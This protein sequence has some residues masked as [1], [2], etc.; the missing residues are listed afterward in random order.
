MTTR[1]DPNRPAGP[2]RAVRALAA[3]LVLAGPAPLRADEGPSPAKIEMGAIDIRSLLD[4]SVEAVMR[5]P[6]RAS[7]A[8]AS[9]FVVTGQD[10]RRHGSRTLAEALGFVPGL[11]AYPGPFEQVGVRGMGILGDFTTR[12]LVLVDGHPLANAMGGDL[13]RGFPVPLSAVEKIE[14]IKGPVGSVYGPTAFLGVVNV[15][16]KGAAPGGEAWAGLEAAQGEVRAGEAS[17]A[18]RGRPGEAEGLVAVDGWKTKGQDWTYADVPPAAFTVRGEDD[19]DALSAYA[20]GQ[21][22]DLGVAGACGHAWRRMPAS[23]PSGGTPLG[24]NTLGGLTCFGEATWQA[25]LSDALTLRGRGAFDYFQRRA[26]LAYAPPPDGIGT[27][28]HGGHDQWETAELRVEW[29]LSEALQLDAGATGQLHQIVQHSRSDAVPLLAVDLSPQFGTLNTWLQAELHPLATVTLHAGVTYFAHSLFAD[30]LTPKL[31]AVWQPTSADVVKAIWSTGFRPP[32]FVEA[33]V[34]DQMLFVANPDL[35]AERVSSLELGYQHH[36]GEVA[37]VSATVFRNDYRDLIKFVMVPAPGLDHV[38]DPANPSDFRSMAQNVESL[39]VVGGELAVTLRWGRWAEGWA[40]LSL[41]KADVSQRANFPR[42][43]ANAGV[44]SRALWSPLLLAAR[45]AAW[46][47]RDKDAASLLPGQR[48]RVPAAASLDLSAA[49][50]VP[51]LTGLAVEVAVKNVLDA[52]S[53]S[54][55]DPKQRPVSELP[56]AARTVRADLRWSF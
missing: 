31:A 38:P 26:I 48:T 29:R 22:R 9:V 32:T 46:S 44:S 19:G 52:A 56:Q 50:D 40:G 42:A 53:P 16:T 5:R 18:W 37:S 41:Q 47:A 15:V 7:Q 27:Y 17:A 4:L 11:F 35:K 28:S 36:F 33:K 23:V 12:L 39:H 3:L 1:T 51:G 54:P 13:G 45:A 49:L 8:P 21:W 34:Q 24:G 10:L 43:T 25:R 55:A 6:S 20:R 14:V 2:P 30:Q